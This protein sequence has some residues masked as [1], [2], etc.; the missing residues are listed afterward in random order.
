MSKVRTLRAEN[1]MTEDSLCATSRNRKGMKS[2][3]ILGHLMVNHLLWGREL[4]KTNDYYNKSLFC[5]DR[6]FK[7]KKKKKSNS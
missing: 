3:G 4:I 1:K 6:A 7:W 2:P 5:L